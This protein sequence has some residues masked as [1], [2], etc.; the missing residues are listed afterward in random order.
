MYRASFYSN[1]NQLMH[2]YIYIYIYIYIYHNTISL[3]ND[4][5]SPLLCVSLPE[6][7]TEMSKHVEA[8]II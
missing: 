5:S 8:N 6:V 3:Y 4:Q 1:F 7:D 2:K